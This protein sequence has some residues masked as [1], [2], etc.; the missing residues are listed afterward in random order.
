M[1]NETKESLGP[2]NKDSQ[3]DNTEYIQPATDQILNTATL[4]CHEE[5]IDPSILQDTL[6]VFGDSCEDIEELSLLSHVIPLVAQNP[7]TP[8]KDL[9]LSP[10]VTREELLE[11]YKWMQSSNMLK[12]VMTSHYYPGYMMIRYA[13]TFLGDLA[14]DPQYLKDVIEH[15]PLTPKRLE[16]H[17]TNG[18][19]NYRCSMCLWHVDNQAKYEGDKEILSTEDWNKVFKQAAEG[20]TEVAIFSGGGE[21]LLRSDLGEV[22]EHANKNGLYTMIYTNGSRLEKL[23]KDNSRLYKSLLNADWLRVSL[24][25]TDDDTYADLVHLPREKK[26]LSRVVRGMRRL[27]DDRDRLGKPLKIGIG[28]VV[29]HQN[30]DQVSEIAKLA[31]ELGVDLLNIREDCIDITQN[32]SLE[33]RE[34]LY[35]QLRD[36]RRDFDNGVYGDMQIDFADTMIAQ[37]NGW[38]KS[39]SVE[40]PSE[41]KV[42]LYRSAIDPYGRVAVCDLVSEPYFATDDLTLG[43][44][45]KNE[46]YARV[47]EDSAERKFKTEDCSKC[48]PGQQAIN[49]LWHKVLEDNKEGIT[50]ENQPL[51]FV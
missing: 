17:V 46:D 44:I 11:A 18:T 31:K 5:E 10:K 24:H 25:S 12:T 39:P 6:K 21:P 36:I 38:E 20:G 22:I 40:T 47:L 4:L 37:M 13:Q 27:I 42:H 33:E 14:R 1:S 9:E 16:V 2:Y 19:C 26:P 41:C 45:S 23:S 30:F 15:K 50:P 28:F 7:T 29:Q 32:L 43:Y 51:L 8:L 35:E 34:V 3:D 48:M 49:A